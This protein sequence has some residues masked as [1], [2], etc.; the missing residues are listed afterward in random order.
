MLKNSSKKPDGMWTLSVVGFAFVLFRLLMG[1][2]EGFT[3]GTFSMQFRE[4]DAGV[5]VA[6]LT[7]TFFSYVARKNKVFTPKE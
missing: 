2:L 6:L 4:I 7:P 3:V 1:M 5:I